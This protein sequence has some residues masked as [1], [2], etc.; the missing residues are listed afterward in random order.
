MSDPFRIFEEVFGSRSSPSGF[1]A[2]RSRRQESFD[3]FNG[4]FGPNVTVR[5][6]G[7]GGLQMS[8]GGSGQSIVFSSGPSDWVSQSYSSRTVNGRTEAVVKRTDT[9]GNEYATYTSADGTT[10][11]TLNGAPHDGSPPGAVAY[12]SERSSRRREPPRHQPPPPITHQSAP[13]SPPRPMQRTRYASP[14]PL[15]RYHSPPSPSAPPP[16][17][18]QTRPNPPGED[19]GIPISSRSWFRMHGF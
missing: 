1:D 9:Q 7:G 2:P 14:P 4:V 18:R 6:G 17:R 13:G 11:H 5:F 12:E 10:R 8:S 19:Q 16:P 15:E 3:P